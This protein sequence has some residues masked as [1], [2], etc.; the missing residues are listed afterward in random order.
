MQVMLKLAQ[1]EI[2]VLGEAI[3]P[4]EACGQ[5]RKNTASSKLTRKPCM[6]DDFQEPKMA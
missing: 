5:D 1:G 2:L 6:A 3:A 4:N